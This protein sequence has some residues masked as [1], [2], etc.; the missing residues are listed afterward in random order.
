MFYQLLSSVAL[1]NKYTKWYISICKNAQLRAT[2][3]KTA[4]VLLGKVE[5]HHIIPKSFNIGGIKDPFNFAYVT[6]REHFILHYLL[7]KMFNS[8]YK[9]KMIYALSQFKQGRVLTARQYEIIKL[10]KSQPCSVDRAASISKSRLLTKKLTCTHCNKSIDPGNYKQFHGDNCKIN[11]LVD[12]TLLV[13]RSASKRQSVLTSIENGT[14]KVGNNFQLNNPSRLKYTCISC[15]R[16]ITGKGAY[17]RFHG[18]NCKYL[19]LSGNQT[20][21]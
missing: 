19:V 9:H 14:H 12:K 1:P 2:S 11:P 10:Y 8:Q 13:V 6:V 7:T 5:C 15:N 17:A 16:E 20:Q 21:T 3:R 4:K 18:I